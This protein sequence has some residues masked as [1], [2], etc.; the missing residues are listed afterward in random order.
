MTELPRTED[1]P[2]SDEGYDAT[3]VEEAFGSF[4]ER[5]R[6]L[7]SVAGELR[8]ELQALRRERAAR[9]PSA[10]PPPRALVEDEAWPVEPGAVTS[11]DWIASVPPP[12]LRPVAVPRLVLEGIFILLVALF[13]GLAGLRPGWIVLLMLAAWALVALSEW[14][15]AAKH[16]RWRLNEI[17][18]PVAQAHAAGESTGPWSMPVVGATVVVGREESEDHT[19]VAKLP[20]PP[21]DSGATAE[22]PAEPATALPEEPVTPPGEITDEQP[23]RR[24]LFRRRRAAE[25]APADPWEG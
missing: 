24:G 6:E 12:V 3:R 22:P 1:L 11:P 23:P 9:T 8:S 13:A 18:E 17:P 2:R 14:A 15:A 4:A 19:V 5:V 20:A 16:A 10:A 7:E 25:P 21:E